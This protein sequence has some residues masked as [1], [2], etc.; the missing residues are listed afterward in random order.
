MD[1]RLRGLL[2]EFCLHFL[3]RTE[4]VDDRLNDVVQVSVEVSQ[5]VETS[6]VTNRQSH[7]CLGTFKLSILPH[8]FAMRALDFLELQV[9]YFDPFLGALALSGDLLV[10]TV[11]LRARDFLHLHQIS[12]RPFFLLV[13][14]SNYLLDLFVKVL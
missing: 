12:L 7:S 3:H 1:E 13:D 6:P 10:N 11:E 4:L 8:N 14:S 5:L 2:D 9:D